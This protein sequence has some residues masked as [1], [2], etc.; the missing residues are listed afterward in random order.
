[1]VHLEYLE[2]EIEHPTR[3]HMFANSVGLVCKL[4]LTLCRIQ[5]TTHF[6][7]ELPLCFLDSWIQKMNNESSEHLRH[8]ENKFATA[9]PDGRDKFHVC[10]Q[11]MILHRTE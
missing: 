5:T 4:D 2:K 7:K 1:M 11:L 10:L 6:N 9:S 3:R 8:Q